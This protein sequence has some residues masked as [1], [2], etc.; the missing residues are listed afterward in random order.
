MAIFLPYYDNSIVNSSIESLHLSMRYSLTIVLIFVLHW[1]TIATHIVGGVFSLQYISGNRYQLK[2]RVYRD[3]LN[4]AANFDPVVSVGIFDL[5]TNAK[6]NE[7]QLNLT[8]SVVL[9]FTGTPCQTAL[10]PGITEE[11]RYIDTITLNPSIYNNTAGYYFSYERCCRN[12]VISNILNPGDAG[13]SI[14]MTIPSPRLYR[15]STP[16]LNMN[17]NV[18]FCVE[19]ETVYNLSFTDADGDQ[20]RYSMTTPING[21]LDQNTPVSNNPAP[22]PYPLISWKAPFNE[23]QQVFG[24]P[25]LSISPNTGQISVT[26][27]NPGIFAVAFKV[28]EFRNNVKL[29]EVHLELQITV[30]NCPQPIP[31]LQITSLNGPGNNVVGN[32]VTFQ[33]GDSGCF[34]FTSTDPTDSVKMKTEISLW[35]QFVDSPSI[36][37]PDSGLLTISNK[38]CL[39]TDCRIATETTL[40]L[41]ITVEDD[42]CPKP[43]KTSYPFNIRIL[44]K[45]L[46]DA[47]D[48]LCMTF[49]N[50]AATT[51]YWGDST[52]LNTDFKQINFYRSQNDGPFTLYDS[53]FDVNARSYKDTQTPDFGSINYRY[54]IRVINT[55][56]YPGPTSDTLSSFEQLEALPDTVKLYAVSVENNKSIRVTWVKSLDKD[57]ARYFVYKEDPSSSRPTKEIYQSANQNDTTFLD[58]DVEVNKKTYC[59]TV[60]VKDTCDNY[61]PK[62]QIGCSI[63]LEGQAMPFANTVN[64]SP[65]AFYNTVNPVY[66]LR[67]KGNLSPDIQFKPLTIIDSAYL[68]TALDPQSFVFSYTVVAQHQGYTP[69]NRP[70]ITYESSSNTIEFNQS[71]QLYIPNA[72]TPNQ[73]GINDIW[74]IRDIFI[75]EFHLSI[76]DKW[77]QV[78]FETRDKSQKWNGNFQRT[79]VAAPSD[80]YIYQLT[81]K[82]LRSPEF[83]LK[84][85]I[86]LLR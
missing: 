32:N 67:I 40:Q 27:L 66:Q 16:D 58:K 70:R 42:G 74:D 49:E 11:G 41:K 15:N 23:Q 6:K 78:V 57:F 46:L 76:Y 79:D 68:D 82:G 43:N 39:K 61:G 5:A 22:G 21:T 7:L 75:D 71:P 24:T 9:P 45:S 85:T 10:P 30:A 2:L 83:K 17:P 31:Q 86:T 29:G 1:N 50:N 44:P 62:G 81:Y 19:K 69:S 34:L 80:V 84:G 51:I 48:L 35:N 33:V 8:S 25:D 3:A 18:L 14:Y 60:V 37:P 59:Y 28:E 36:T 64:W 4:G 72:F 56:G 63:L 12:G 65:F 13:I 73:D 20:V 54:Y 77:G 53:I 38:V 47:V 55:C 52:P 26:P